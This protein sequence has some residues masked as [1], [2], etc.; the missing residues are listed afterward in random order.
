M[1]GRILEWLALEDDFRTPEISQFVAEFP[2]FT[3][4]FTL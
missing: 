4:D 1:I 3:F 2:Q